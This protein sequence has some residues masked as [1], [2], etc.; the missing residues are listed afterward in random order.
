MKNKQE[1]SEKK[2]DKMI[3]G[4]EGNQHITLAFF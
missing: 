4:W 2:T 1:L 3:L